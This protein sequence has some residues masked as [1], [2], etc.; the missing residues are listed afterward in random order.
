V[1]PSEAPPLRGRELRRRYTTA[2]VSVLDWEEATR[3]VA[4]GAGDPQTNLNLAWQLLYRLEPELYDRLAGAERLHPGVIA[5]LPRNVERI[6]EVGAGSGRLTLELIDRA[7]ELVAVEPAAPLRQL[8][9][10]K[11]S[12][13]DT[14]QEVRLMHGFF[15]DLPVT[16]DC[17]DLVVTCSA[18]TPAPCHG[19]ERGLAEMERV[20]KPG[21][22]VVI[23][24]PNNVGWLAGHGYRYRSFV[25]E[26]C[27]E[28]SSHDEAAE[29][30]EVFYPSA[31]ADIRRRGGSQVPYKLLGI[32]P[33]RDLAFKVMA[34]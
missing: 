6:V 29:V 16:D 12:L 11:L 22:Q 31:V 17:A 30:A 9:S 34:R 23:V 19:G 26:M 1:I 27:V 10:Q 15:D 5:W 8:L 28:F 18:L 2:D 24:W 20:C 4:S 7:R 3:F 33:P 32:N 13:A 14:R 25:G 21:G